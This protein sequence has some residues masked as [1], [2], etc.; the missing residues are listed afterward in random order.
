M[1]CSKA[2]KYCVLSEYI[3]DDTPQQ[4]NGRTFWCSNTCWPIQC[5]S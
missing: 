3:S 2:Q 1:M 4:Y 5:C